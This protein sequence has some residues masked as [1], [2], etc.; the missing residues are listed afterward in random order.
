MH[1]PSGLGFFENQL[2]A[3]TR[4]QIRLVG[5]AQTNHWAIGAQVKVTADGSTQLQELGVGWTFLVVKMIDSCTL[6]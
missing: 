3:T 1:E 6:A 2:G 4:V 5:G